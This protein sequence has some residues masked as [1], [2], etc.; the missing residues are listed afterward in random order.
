[1][2]CRNRAKAELVQQEILSLSQGN[3]SLFVL[4]GDCSLRADVVRIWDEFVAHSRQTR[5]AV[6]LN[7]L[8]CNAGALTLER[9]V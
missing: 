1:M 4:E 9:Y 8:L 6:T 7:G 3:T 2:V 5:E